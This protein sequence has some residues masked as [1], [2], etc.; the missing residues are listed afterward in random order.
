M[1]VPALERPS[2]DRNCVAERLRRWRNVAAGEKCRCEI[3]NASRKTRNR[4]IRTMEHQ[5]R[6]IGTIA[7]KDEPKPIPV[8]D[9]EKS[10]GGTRSLR[11]H[12]CINCLPGGITDQHERCGSNSCREH[13]RVE[14]YV[15]DKRWIDDDITPS[16]LMKRRDQFYSG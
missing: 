7:V 5:R 15:R 12:I 6:N 4:N 9:A 8:D 14:W 16:I 3:L 13:H 10:V 2:R 11:Q 1:S